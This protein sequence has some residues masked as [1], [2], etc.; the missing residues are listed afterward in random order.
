MITKVSL[1]CWRSH[2]DSEFV[3][4][5]GT[6][7]LLGILG[8]GKSS[9]LDGICFALFGTFPTLQTRKLKLEDLLMKKPVEKTRADVEV[10]F[11]LNGN[12]YSVKRTIEKGRGTTYSE[13][14][15]NGK[16]LES[17]NSSRVTELVEKT[18]KV[19]YDLFS[20]AIYSEQNSLDY[21]LTIPKGMRM[22]KID[23][24]LMIDRFEKARAG[25]VSLINKITDRKIG[26]QSIIENINIDELRRII[27]E[28]KGSL[29]REWNEK[30]THERKLSQ[31]TVTKERLEKEYLELKN[32]RENLELLKREEK[33]IASAIEETFI[34]LSNLEKSLK[35]VDRESVE[36]NLK[37]F[38][39]YSSELERLLKEKEEL[40]EKRSNQA[41]RSKGELESF[42]KQTLERLKSEFDERLRIVKE[43]DGKKLN[44]KELEKEAES[45]KKVL[46]KLVGEIEVLSSKIKDLENLISEINETGGKCPICDTKL[47]KEKKT[48]LIKQKLFQI[49]K[50]KE[51][52][53]ESHSKKE[54]TEKQIKNL[55]EITYSLQEMLDEIKDFDKIKTEF[56][57]AQNVYKVLN[58]STSKMEGEVLSLRADV[59]KFQDELKDV[60]GK[61]Q[62]FELLALRSVGYKEKE[63]R[64][65]QL[66]RERQRLADHIANAEAIISKKDLNA[67]ESELRKIIAEEREYATRIVSLEP[68]IKEK[69]ARLKDLEQTMNNTLKE[70]EE[71]KKLDELIAQLKVFEK[72]VEETQQELRKEFVTSVNFAMS[73]LWP[74]LYPYRDFASAKLSVDENDYVL[75]LQE[76][77]GKWINVEGF[78]SGGERSIAALTLR[79]AFALVLAPQLKWLVLDEPTHNLDTKAVEDLAATLSERIGNFVDQVFLITHD[80][81]LENAVTGSLYRLERDKSK[82][83][84][85]RAMLVA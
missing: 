65:Q 28:L 56:E 69:E 82:D 3:F 58:E 50:L 47:T 35:G 18:L 48:L 73:E 10:Y 79:I 14:R 33:G 84:F 54:L 77:T 64:M 76:R 59:E 12:S 1:K 53:K 41:A 15:E 49:R 32:A 22:R 36:K 44:E 37:E 67:V 66:L 78:A 25:A 68:V 27:E 63:L 57:N 81:K 51:K 11:H 74:N 5:N 9:V 30:S 8:S 20:K 85:T 60:M 23:E 80:E 52:M 39:R 2:L 46:E 16:I 72:A 7:A 34:S 26:K 62:K 13:I 71:V 55:E 83:G 45:K 75:Q 19:N 29:N 43:L 61:K 6:N 21:F 31:T 42:N 24:L 17:P 4:T 70:K 40:Y 38:I